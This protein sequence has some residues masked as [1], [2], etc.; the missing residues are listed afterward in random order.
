MVLSFSN[1]GDL[2]HC[3]VGNKVF[4]VLTHKL[5]VGTITKL[6]FKGIGCREEINSTQCIILYEDLTK[7]YSY[8][9]RT[10]NLDLLRSDFM[11]DKRAFGFN[12]IRK[13]RFNRLQKQYQSG[14]INF[15]TYLRRLRYK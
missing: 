11:V 5:E 7:L 13:G 12:P 8:M 2:E 9:T 6:N 1:G 15:K 3:T 14:Q 4:K 10:Y